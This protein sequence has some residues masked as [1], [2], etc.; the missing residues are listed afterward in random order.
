MR[1]NIEPLKKKDAATVI[2]F[3]FTLT[4]SELDADQ[5]SAIGAEE[6]ENIR[7]YGSI[8]PKTGANVIE[9]MIFIDYAI[10][11]KFTASC[12]RCDEKVIQSLKVKGEKY[13]AGK[14][15]EDDE[16]FYIVDSNIV[17]LTEFAI[18]FLM[19][20]VPVRY[21]CDED[22]K[23]LCPK[24]GKNLNMGECGCPKK[25]VNPSFKVLDNF[26]D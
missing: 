2:D 16:N 1:V 18:E 17:D 11:A 3:D 26:F 7:V 9:T 10:D 12:S 23:G 5:L 13:I 19:L 24:C 6:I 8:T 14:D 20:E 25:E 15:K 22:C 21:L 4:N